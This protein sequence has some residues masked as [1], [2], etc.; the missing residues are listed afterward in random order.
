M[1]EEANSK[2]WTDLETMGAIAWVRDS[3][4]P[5]SERRFPSQMLLALKG[6][7]QNKIERAKGRLVLNGSSMV[8]GVPLST[9]ES[10]WH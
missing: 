9:K 7:A 5:K 6:D 4:V 10:V 8:Q 1:V 3:D 2:E